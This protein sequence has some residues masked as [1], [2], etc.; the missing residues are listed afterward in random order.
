MPVLAGFVPGQDLEV[1]HRAAEMAH[2]LGVKLL[3]SILGGAGV[4]WSFLV[5]SGN[6]T[7]ALGQLAE[8]AD[9]SVIVVG[10]R[11]SGLGNLL[12][13]LL[14]GPVGRSAHTPPTPA[15]SGHS[16]RT[17][18]SPGGRRE[19]AYLNQCYSPTKP[20]AAEP[21]LALARRTAATDSG[22]QP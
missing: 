6:P 16:T 18:K 3:H 8:S 2:S 15:R 7:Q 10:T 12:E 5:L 4:R 14:V 21:R 13:Q 19:L 9:V 20:V 22:Q 17:S 11:E 1:V